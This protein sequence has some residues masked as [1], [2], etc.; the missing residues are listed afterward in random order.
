MQHTQEHKALRPWRR[1]AEKEFGN[2]TAFVHNAGLWPGLTTQRTA[3]MPA[4]VDFGDENF[5]EF[6]DYFFR[7]RSARSSL[8]LLT[9]A[10]IRGQPDTN[11]S[12]H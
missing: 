6:F 10:C 7:V 2:V 8:F 5:Y 11:T 9:Q 12:L 1:V 3:Q 4:S